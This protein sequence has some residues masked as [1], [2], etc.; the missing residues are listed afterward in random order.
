MATKDI[1]LAEIDEL[2]ALPAGEFVAA[3]NALAKRLRGEKHKAEA[4]EV[5]ALRKPTVVAAS[6]NRV[7]RDKADAVAVLI[8]AAHGVADAQREVMSGGDAKALRA[9][10][11]AQRGALA[12]VADAAVRIAGANNADAVSATLDAA[13]A[14]EG[15]TERLRAGTLTETL[16]APAGF[17]F[18]PD[19]EST[20][21][22]PR[23]KPTVKARTGKAAPRATA[24]A[25]EG[26]AGTTAASRKAAAE[27]RR[28]VVRRERELEN[29]ERKRTDAAHTLDDARE[30]LSA[31]EQELA[32][33]ERRVRDATSTRDRAAT[34]LAAAVEERDRLADDL[35]QAWSRL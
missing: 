19:A 34:A 18:G 15:L 14:D 20:S 13:L 2:Y 8:D 1:E 12:E 11:A 28:E 24:I 3:R 27:A 23:Q 21:A 31:A 29:A 33:T 6:L 4:A 25:D 16:D 22:V 32:A 30:V 26:T 5:A 35:A 7:A 9:A 10:A 17:G